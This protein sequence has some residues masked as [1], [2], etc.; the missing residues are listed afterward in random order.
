MELHVAFEVC[1]S[2]PF[3]PCFLLVSR[4]GKIELT[5]LGMHAQNTLPYFVVLF[6][7]VQETLSDAPST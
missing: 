3:T 4:E 1:F 6:L 5:L 2:S 7:P